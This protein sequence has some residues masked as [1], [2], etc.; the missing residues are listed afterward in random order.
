MPQSLSNPWVLRAA[1]EKGVGAYDS[2]G[3][4]DFDDGSFV[5][6][7]GDVQAFC[8]V[9]GKELSKE[10]VAWEGRSYSLFELPGPAVDGDS[11]IHEKIQVQDQSEHIIETFDLTYSSRTT[12]D[13]STCFDAFL[14]AAY[15]LRRSILKA[16]RALPPTVCWP[17]VLEKFCAYVDDDPARQASIVDLAR[18][19]PLHLDK[20]TKQPWRTL[21][22]IRDLERI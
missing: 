3:A 18:E 10:R 7:S 13:T 5:L 17:K 19:L 11:S 22:R 2:Q 20:V 8:S 16:D 15:F 1:F 6:Y 9:S 14:N 4:L 12:S 21:K